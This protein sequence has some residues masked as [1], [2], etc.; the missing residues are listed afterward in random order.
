MFPTFSAAREALR[1]G[2]ASAEELAR[3]YLA[4]LE[5]AA[6]LNIFLDVAPEAV[7]AR[8]REVDA[9]QAAGADLPL[10]GLMLAVKDVIAMKG[11]RLTC[12]S[13]MLED[14]RSL[15]DAHVIER[16]HAAG[17]TVIGRV[18]CDEFAMG[19]SNENSHFGPA[20]NPH[21]PERVPGGSSG[22]SAA[23]VAAGLCNAALGSDTGGSIRQPAAFCGVVGL[24]PTYGRVS[25]YGLAAY[26]SSFDSIGP[27]APS[28]EDAARVLGVVAGLD[29]RDA[30]SAPAPTPDYAAEVGAPVEGVRIGLPREY[31]A[32]GLDPAIRALLEQQAD[33]LAARGAHV[34]EVSLPYTEY[35]IAAYY[36]LAAAEASSNLARYD[37]IRYGYRADLDALRR[38]LA[39][40]RR[41]LEADMAAARAAGDTAAQAEALRRADAQESALRRLYVQSRTE[42]FGEEVKR[43]IMLGTYVL[44]SGYYSAYYDKAQRV[45]T[46]IRRDFEQA[47]GQVDVLLTPATPT[48]A[49]KIGSKTSDPLEMYLSDVYTVTANLAG[50]PGLVVP[51]GLHPREGLPVGM[52]LLGPPFSEGLLCRVGEAAMQA[53]APPASANDK[54]PKGIV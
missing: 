32:E 51:V 47:F 21:D 54:Q 12:G 40:E 5:G 41:A 18:N 27:L 37:G 38:S 4:A 39:E 14:F 26:A 29:P 2:R 22:G 43:R 49:F 44:S 7:L 17:A 15:Y 42:G 24:K 52:Q 34:Q 10:A 3:A 6:A 33:A 53:A 11:R 30:T 13:R 28:V 8:A 16:L 1:E 31:F 48:V 23:A 46:L 35:G 20:R 50:A 45:R 19:S 36:I 9:Q 25:R